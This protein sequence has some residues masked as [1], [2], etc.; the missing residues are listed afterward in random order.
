MREHDTMRKNVTRQVSE[1]M[2]V[3]KIA[4]KK[5]QSRVK[6][7]RVIFQILSDKVCTYVAKQKFINQ[8]W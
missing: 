6:I 4:Y 3:W 5:S 8:F 2:E 1:R 7:D